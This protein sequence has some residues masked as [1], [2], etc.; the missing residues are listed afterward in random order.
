MHFSGEMVPTEQAAVSLRLASA[1]ANSGGYLKHVNALKQR[2]QPYFAVIE[3]IL[4]KHNVPNDFKYLPLIESNWKADAVSTAGAVGYWQFMDETARDMGLKIDGPADERED[5]R[6]ST[7][8]AARYIKFLYKKLGSWTLVAAAY[9]GG[10]GMIQNKVRRAG[11]RDYYALTLNEETGYYLYRALAMKEL[12]NRAG[13]YANRAD[14]GLLASAGNPYEQ[15]REQ[16]RRMGWLND[17]EPEPIGDP[18]ENDPFAT[19]RP[20]SAV[21][22]SVLVRLL[23]DNSKLV[24]NEFS[25]DVT[26]RLLKAGKPKVGERWAF[27]LRQDVTIAEDEFKAGDV[28]YALVDDVDARGVVY[29][30]ATKMVSSVSKAIVPVT[31][32]AVNPNTGLAGIYVPKTTKADWEVSWKVQ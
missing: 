6:K 22:D 13:F 26:A 31:L 11:H 21:M 32:L 12:F 15:E 23:S 20:E 28:L 10:V 30:R 7:E 16:A 29:L 1:L 17:T 14:G 8:A 9:N 18:I 3:P 27:K 19:T 24:S 5:L 25:G 4:A 2:S